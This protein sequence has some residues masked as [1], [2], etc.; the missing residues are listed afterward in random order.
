MAVIWM[1]EGKADLGEFIGVIEPQ[2]SPARTDC[3]D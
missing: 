3:R 2:I 1:S